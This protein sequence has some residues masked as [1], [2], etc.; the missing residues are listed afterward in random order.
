[1]ATRSRGGPVPSRGSLASLTVVTPRHNNTQLLWLDS[2][3]LSLSFL[4]FQGQTGVYGCNFSPQLHYIIFFLY[5][6]FLSSFKVI[7]AFLEK[8]PISQY[9]FIIQSIYSPLSLSSYKQFLLT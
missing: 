6:I 9:V 5:P 1:M 4:L 8:Q 3:S 2:L 7:A